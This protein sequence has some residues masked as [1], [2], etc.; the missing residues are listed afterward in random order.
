VCFGVLPCRHCGRTCV[1]KPCWS[2]MGSWSCLVLSGFQLVDSRESSAGWVQVIQMG[3]QFVLRSLIHA[4]L[5]RLHH[6]AQVVSSAAGQVSSLPNAM[7]VVR[8]LCCLSAMEAC[9][10]SLCR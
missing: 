8:A 5:V 9:T 6:V 10:R 7:V 4:P 3:Y 2:W 1:C